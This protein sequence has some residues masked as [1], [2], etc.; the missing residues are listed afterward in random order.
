MKYKTA[1]SLNRRI[2]S[3]NLQFVTLIL[4]LFTNL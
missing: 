1:E 2:S 3:Q 4:D